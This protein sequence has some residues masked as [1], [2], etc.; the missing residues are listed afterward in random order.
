M[1]WTI[2]TIVDLYIGLVVLDAM[3]PSIPLSKLRRL[4]T[5]RRVILGLIGVC[6]IVLVAQI[7]LRYGWLRP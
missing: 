1:G 6:G 5:A 2:F 3:K 7:V 4:R